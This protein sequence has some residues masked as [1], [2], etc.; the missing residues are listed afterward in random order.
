MF[1]RHTALCPWY[2]DRKND[3]LCS[4]QYSL[5]TEHCTVY[6]LPLHSYSATAT[7]LPYRVRIEPNLC[8]PIT[9]LVRHMGGRI[10]VIQ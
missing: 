3:M 1:S 8:N 6:T 2:A 7:S 10:V 9:N 5:N 4:V